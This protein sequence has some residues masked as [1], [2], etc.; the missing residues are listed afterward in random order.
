MVYGLSGMVIIN[1]NLFFPLPTGVTSAQG[2][3]EMSIGERAER[4]F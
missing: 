3:I 2:I 4:P 1:N